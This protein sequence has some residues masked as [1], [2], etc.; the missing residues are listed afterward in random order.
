[1]AQYTFIEGTKYLITTD[2]WFFAPD[3]KQYKAVWGK[4]AILPDSILGVKTN[5]KSTNWYARVGNNANHVIIAGC[6]IHYAVRC[7]KKPNQGSF[8]NYEVNNG[9]VVE[10]TQPESRIWVTE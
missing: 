8:K 10:F 2:N 3:G 5:T 7:E 9:V 6:Q 4:V 1:M